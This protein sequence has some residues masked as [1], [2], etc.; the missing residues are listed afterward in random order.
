MGAPI[1]LSTDVPAGTGLILNAR[2]LATVY[3]R[4]PI[5]VEYGTVGDQFQRNVVSIRAEE[6]LAFAVTRPAAAVSVTA[7]N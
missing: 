6:R 7:L 5:T 1:H 2:E 4:T 3:N